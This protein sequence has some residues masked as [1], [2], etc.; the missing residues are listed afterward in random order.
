MLFLERSKNQLLFTDRPG[1]PPKD[2]I[3]DHALIV[4]ETPDRSV[5]SFV[6]SAPGVRERKPEFIGFSKS[7]DRGISVQA[8][9]Q[10]VIRVTE[11]TFPCNRVPELLEQFMK[12]RKFHTRKEAPET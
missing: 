4:E 12:F 7:P 10:I 2:R 3:L 6:I 11:I 9:D 1:Y 8:G 5:A